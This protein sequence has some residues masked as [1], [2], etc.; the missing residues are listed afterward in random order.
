MFFS[1]NN[2]MGNASKVSSNGILYA[3]H[4]RKDTL[5]GGEVR[6]L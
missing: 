6:G 5:Y 3:R 1:F 2:Q 4:R